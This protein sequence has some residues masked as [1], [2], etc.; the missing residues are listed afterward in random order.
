MM[1]NEEGLKVTKYLNWMICK[2]G[3]RYYCSSDDWRTMTFIQTFNGNC[4]CCSQ[5][6]PLFTS[7]IPHRSKV[8]SQPF[9]MAP[10]CPRSGATI[11]DFRC[12]PRVLGGMLHVLP[13]S[14]GLLQLYYCAVSMTCH[15]VQQIYS[16]CLLFYS[17]VKAKS[18]C[19]VICPRSCQSLPHPGILY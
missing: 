1:F 11:L 17:T 14:P 3:T 7:V 13:P 12:C 6:W 10:N 4:E 5:F 9:I 19:V 2:S 8:C 15:V 18:H 16:G